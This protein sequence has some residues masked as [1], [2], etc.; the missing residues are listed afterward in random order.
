MKK[1]AQINKTMRK[2]TCKCNRCTGIGNN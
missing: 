2:E 1:E